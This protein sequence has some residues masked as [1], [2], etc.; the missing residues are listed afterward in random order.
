D[1]A[2]PAI[3]STVRIRNG[4]QLPTNGRILI[5]NKRATPP[6]TSVGDNPKRFA[7]GTAS[8]P[9]IAKQNPGSEVKNPAV[10]LLTPKE[11][12]TCPITG[13]RDEIPAR[14]FTAT[15]VTARSASPNPTVVFLA[16][17]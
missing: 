16:T 1:T 7:I 6:A 15:N 11:S 4:R 5:P 8:Q 10:E 12:A 14:K 13:A 9:I 2:M 17:Q 3:N